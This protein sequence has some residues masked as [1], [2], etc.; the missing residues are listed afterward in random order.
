MIVMITL[1]SFT[2]WLE[3]HGLRYEVGKN[4]CDCVDYTIFVNFWVKGK[5]ST[6]Y[7]L[8]NGGYRLNKVEVNTIKDVEGIL[9]WE[10]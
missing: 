8:D 9:D 3:S 7:F 2:D 5:V 1:K 10:L 6:F 4:W